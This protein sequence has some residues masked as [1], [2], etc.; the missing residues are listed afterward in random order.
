[1]GFQLRQARWPIFSNIMGQKR[2]PNPQTVYIA[3]GS[4]R[5]ASSIG[6]HNPAG[7]LTSC[8]ATQ[9]AAGQRSLLPVHWTPQSRGLATSCR[10]TQPA[11]GASG[12]GSALGT[13]FARNRKDNL[14]ESRF[15]HQASLV[16]GFFW[17]AFVLL[18]F[19]SVC[20]V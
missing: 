5:L 18:L 8:R 9:P 17:V 6:R 1:M 20:F 14:E 19:F 2:G 15:F 7:L 12:V 13:H 3:A 4:L 11:A 10:A 16:F